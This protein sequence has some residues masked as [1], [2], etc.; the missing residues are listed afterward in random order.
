MAE[1]AID[2]DTNALRLT[3]ELS[4]GSYSGY[5]PALMASTLGQ[6]NFAP[7]P[8]G[9]GLFIGWDKDNSS[10]TYGIDTTIGTP[11]TGSQATIDFDLIPIG[12]FNKPRD[13]TMVEY[14]LSRPM[15]SGE[16]IVVNTRLIFDVT[17]TGYT[18]T[19]TDSTVGNYSGTASINTQNAQ[20]LQVQAVINSTASN[21]S[22]LRLRHIR[23]LGLVGPTL[24]NN[25]QL[26]L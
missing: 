2:L 11:Y 16:S 13:N 6:A 5:A 26:G 15:V 8:G 22:Y 1:W 14:K 24:A 25:Q 21:P 4:Y 9:S 19:L 18:P 23:L 10:F 7:G 17:S 3:N 12:T 20:W